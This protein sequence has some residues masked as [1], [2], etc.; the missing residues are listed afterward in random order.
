VEVK[1]SI[2]SDVLL[3]LGSMIGW[4]AF[5]RR[6]LGPPS[7]QE[8]AY[9]HIPLRDDCSAHLELIIVKTQ[10]GMTVGFPQPPPE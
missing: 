5:E 6:G 7:L 8:P 1:G 2:H 3:F 4:S 10:P 9:S